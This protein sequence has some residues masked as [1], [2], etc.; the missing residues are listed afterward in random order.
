MNFRTQIPICKQSDNLIDYHSRLLLLGSC[1]SE[2]IGGKL[3]YFKFQSEINPFGILFHPKAIETFLDRVTHKKLYTEDELVFHNEQYHCFDAHSCLS[4]ANKNSLLNNLNSIIELTAKKISE[5]THV[6][7]TLGT[8]WVYEYN[9]TGKIVANC[10][11]IPQKQ[12]NKQLLSVDQIKNSLINIEQQIRSIKPKAQLIYTVS[13]VRH[14]KDGFVQ[15]QQSKAHLLTAIHQVTNSTNECYFPSYE[16]M[17]DE[18]RDYRF[19]KEDMIHPNQ[20]AIDYVWS[21]FKDTWIS[22]SAYI[23]MK[24]V[25]VIQ[26]GLNHTAFNPDSDQHQQFLNNL[27]IKKENLLRDFPFMKFK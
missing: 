9:N 6:I 18:L 21:K 1:F 12:F 22:E 20:V 17:M 7:I 11:K 4:N 16:I 25:E 5:A 8:A 13:P 10:H 24:E 26:K 15:N 19:Y 3:S 23:T 27:E 2:N 14:I